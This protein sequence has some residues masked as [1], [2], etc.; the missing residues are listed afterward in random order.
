MDV[1]TENEKRG[2]FQEIL[3]EMAKDSCDI[4]DPE[5]CLSLC[6]RLTEI[7]TTNENGEKFR[8]FYSDIFSVLTLLQQE[9]ADGSIEIL[10]A[11]LSSIREKYPAYSKECGDDGHVSICIKKLYDHVSLDISRIQF[12]TRTNHTMANTTLR[13]LQAQLDSFHDEILDAREKTQDSMENYSRL[14]SQVQEL[15]ETMQGLRDSIQAAQGLSKKVSKAK[16]KI[17]QFKK[18]L[19]DSK[20]EYIAI[21]GIFA[22]VV[23][24]FN[25]GISFTTSVIQGIAGG[26]IYRLIGIILLVGIILIN[27]LL[28]LLHYV[29][30]LIYG[31]Q[32][33]DMNPLVIS[34]TVLCFLLFCL[35]LAWRN[36]LFGN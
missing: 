8:H 27:L 34:N 17:S 6:L 12:L 26:N 36:N 24:T 35:L 22:A 3:L 21:L 9:E 29:N 11:N 16:T 25:A 18:E 7:Y 32:E 2:Q 1:K 31:R 28:G 23:L 30:R 14:D 13:D 4:A 15:G 5:T 20:K 10:G 33:E 19:E